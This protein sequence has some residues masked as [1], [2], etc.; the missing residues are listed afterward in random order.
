LYAFHKKYDLSYYCK[1]TLIIVF[2]ERLNERGV[3]FQITQ[4]IGAVLAAWLGDNLA[5]TFGFDS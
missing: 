2:E 3:L 4:L 1:M 5:D